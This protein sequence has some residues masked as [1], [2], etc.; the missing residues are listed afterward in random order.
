MQPHRQ[1]LPLHHGPCLRLLTK[2]L[3]FPLLRIPPNPTIVSCRSDLRHQKVEPN[4]PIIPYR[5]FLNQFRELI[6]ILP[7]G[8]IS[9]V[10]PAE[11]TV[12]VH[13]HAHVSLSD[14]VVEDVA[15]DSWV[16]GFQEAEHCVGS[17]KGYSD[18]TG[19]LETKTCKRAWVIT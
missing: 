3:H 18:I 16:W 9:D 6:S 10:F 2:L 4:I 7:N 8:L 12:F 15:I 11:G 5:C 1:K 13:N 14:G 19:V 17:A